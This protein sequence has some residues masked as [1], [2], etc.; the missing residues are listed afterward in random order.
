MQSVRKLVA[1]PLFLVSALALAPEPGFA[2]LVTCTGQSASRVTS[3]VNCGEQE[4]D[5]VVMRYEL[6]TTTV[7]KAPEIVSL[8]CEAQVGLQYF[9]K[10]TLASVEAEI[11]NETC[12]ASSGSFVVSVRT[13]D[14][15]GEQN[16]LEFE[17]SWARDD[18]R[19]V[20]IKAEYEIGDNVELVRARA[21]KIRCTCT[22]AE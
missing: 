8:A 21:Q 12:A 11:D 15:N 18:D 2:Q 14:A 19:T 9:Q 4:R 13:L 7:I 10:N 16:T 17:Q 3:D 5:D 1:L 22:N 6:E 20:T